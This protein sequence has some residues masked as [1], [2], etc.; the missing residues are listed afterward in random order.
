MNITAVYNSHSVYIQYD[1]TY[2]YNSISEHTLVTSLFSWP[3][4]RL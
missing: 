4:F 3:L 1:S 2:G